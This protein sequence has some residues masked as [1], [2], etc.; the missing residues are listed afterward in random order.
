M[1]TRDMVV[2]L[3]RHEDD[4]DSALNVQNIFQ[5]LP[6]EWFV[7]PIHQLVPRSFQGAIVM[8]FA[9]HEDKEGVPQYTWWELFLNSLKQVDTY[10]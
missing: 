3:I 8:V 2:T 7:T 4:E 6:E 5:G 10:L 9:Y 1:A